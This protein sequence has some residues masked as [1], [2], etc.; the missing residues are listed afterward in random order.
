MRG[1]LV[2]T[3]GGGSPAGS[4]D[5]GAQ[6]CALGTASQ[7]GS[8]LPTPLA[9]PATSQT[10]TT[11]ASSRA[12]IRLS[13]SP[14]YPN[15]RGTARFENDGGSTRLRVELNGASALGGSTLDALIGGTKVGSM[16]VEDRGRARLDLRGSTA[17]PM[18]VADTTL[19]IKTPQGV[20]VAS[21]TF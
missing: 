3:G 6:A 19:E 5:A 20:L 11:F 17:V 16:G 4:S 18:A 13:G 7:T 1:T 2:V 12:E 9:T 10:A 14:T 8:S 21:G 15:V